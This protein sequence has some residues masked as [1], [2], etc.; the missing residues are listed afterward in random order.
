MLT[1][2]TTAAT[3]VITVLFI[4]L[5]IVVMLFLRRKDN[6]F[7]VIIQINGPKIILHRHCL[8]SRGKKNPFRRH[9]SLVGEMLGKGYLYHP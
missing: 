8:Q 5:V 1:A 3:I 2:A 9:S 6:V 7:A 4:S